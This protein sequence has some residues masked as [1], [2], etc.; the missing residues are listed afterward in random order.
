MFMRRADRHL[1]NVDSLAESTEDSGVHV[2]VLLV[3]SK[4]PT[5]IANPERRVAVVEK[6]AVEAV[7]STRTAGCGL[8]RSTPGCAQAV[9]RTG[10]RQ[11]TGFAEVP[12]GVHGARQEI[13][14]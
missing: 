9:S 1:C 11:I 2:R 14:S 10:T 6:P 5:W 7:M 8:S 13:A 12:R 4:S 3:P